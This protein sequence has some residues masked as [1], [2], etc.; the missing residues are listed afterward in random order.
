MLNNLEVV[1][2]NSNNIL[3]RL[4]LCWGHLD[5]WRNIQIVHK[6]KEWLS[7]AN[8]VF[9]P[10]TLIAYEN[11]IPVGMIEFMPQ[12]LLRQLG[13]CPC[14]IDVEQ[15]EIES[16][17]ILGKEFD[18]YLFISCLSVAKHHQGKRIGKTLL[19]HF[20]KNQVLKESDGALAYARER[21]QNWEKFIHWPAGPEEFYF[22]AGFSTAK[23]LEKPAGRILLYKK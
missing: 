6:S 22:K 13:L 14:R 7:K 12:R 11:R 19:N 2:M 4:W 15:G 17:Y 21:D 16:R 5:N 23:T 3:D 8:A 1:A 20:L 10:T 18:N 9:V